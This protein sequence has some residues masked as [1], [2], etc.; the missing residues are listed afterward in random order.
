MRPPHL[1]ALAGVVALSVALG[2]VLRSEPVETAE[3]APAPT[4]SGTA[5]PPTTLAFVLAA[6]APGGEDL[7]EAEEELTEEANT[8][9]T[10]TT[11]TTVPVTTATQAPIKET[12]SKTQSSSG[13]TQNQPTTTTTQVASPTATVQAGFRSDYEGEFRSRINSLRASNGLG[14]LSS[15]GSL[16]SRA[17]DWAKS[18]SDSNKLKHSNI[19]NLLPPW[20]AAGE[21]V[22]KGGSVGSIF[23]SLA[24]SSGHLAN[25]VGDYTN[26]GVGVWVDE[27]GTL[28]TVHVFTR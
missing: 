11:T 19:S 14:A 9:A 24:G 22:G 18:M 8:R 6:E 21:N 26:V 17:R 3:V 5:T 28:W 1:Y 13:G 16:N 7:A 10:S 20:S 15:N 25:M 12:K 2:F 4:F 23:S 27:N